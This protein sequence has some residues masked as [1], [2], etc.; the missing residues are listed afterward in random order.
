MNDA[1]DLGIVTYDRGGDGSLEIW[2]AWINTESNSI[3]IINHGLSWLK[4][5]SYDAVL[6]LSASTK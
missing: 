6:Q 3:R 5:S 2:L 4:S 1:I